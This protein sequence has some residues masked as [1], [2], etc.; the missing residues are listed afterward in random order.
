MVIAAG[1][2]GCALEDEVGDAAVR[3]RT[4]ARA[5]RGAVGVGDGGAAGPGVEA[6]AGTDAGSLVLVGDGGAREGG[7]PAAGSS[8]CA[9]GMET[10]STAGTFTF[11]V[12]VYETL[13]VELW[14][15]GGGGEAS[16]ATT[17]AT[18][19]GRSSFGDTLAAE[20]GRAGT[21]AAGGAGGTAMG[22]D[23]NLPGGGGGPGCHYPAICGLG[24]GGSAPRGGMGGAS[25]IALDACSGGDGR[26]G[27]SPGGGGAPSWSC[28]GPWWERMGWGDSGGAGGAGAYATRAF[29]PGAVPPGPISVVVGAAGVGS[30]GQRSSGFPGTGRNPGVY[31]AGNGGAGRVLVRWTCPVVTSPR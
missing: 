18:D 20:G 21:Y 31:T 28:Q 23:M 3:A 29:A 1:L 16:G 25:A 22:G 17:R 5:D 8:T 14:G 10:W 30:Q 2:S 6:G 27:E 9:E 15:A 19:G 26:D 12:P 4:D 7:S 24:A 11:M 13:T